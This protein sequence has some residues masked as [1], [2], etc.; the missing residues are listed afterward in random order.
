MDNYQEIID[1]YYIGH[2][3]AKNILITHGKLVRDKA[4]H[5]S[6]NKPELNIDE[7]FV[8]EASILHDIGMILTNAQ[9]IDCF[10]TYPYICHGYLGRELLDRENMEKAALVAERHTGTGLSI[11]EIIKQSL[12]LPHRDMLPI[13]IEEQ[14]ICFAD[15]FFSKNKDLTR[16]K[17]VSKIRKN[18]LKYGDEHLKKFDNWCEL[19]L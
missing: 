2:N 6:Q 9:E 12:P 1:R 19:F 7:D 17:S 5:I 10:G 4:L 3:K 16:E 11:N 13:S 15:K 18:L 8:E 14:L